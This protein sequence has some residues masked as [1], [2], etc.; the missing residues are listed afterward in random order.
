MSVQVLVLRKGRSTRALLHKFFVEK[1]ISNLLSHLAVVVMVM[2]TLR[3]WI[4]LF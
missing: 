4:L 1:C 2:V 3:V